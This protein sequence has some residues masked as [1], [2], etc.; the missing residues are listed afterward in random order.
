M[1]TS[2]DERRYGNVLRRNEKKPGNVRV[3]NLPTESSSLSRA[4]SVSRLPVLSHDRT[5]RRYLVLPRP[6]I[7]AHIEPNDVPAKV[8]LSTF[9][10]DPTVPRFSSPDPLSF[11]H[12]ALAG[13]RRRRKL[14]NEAPK[15]P[16]W[17]CERCVGRIS[18]LAFSFVRVC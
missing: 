12:A 2:V 11:S 1:K 14:R 17:P 8:R 3:R 18:L 4:R 9:R 7:I 10:T 15:L 13:G 6:I 16:K 5:T